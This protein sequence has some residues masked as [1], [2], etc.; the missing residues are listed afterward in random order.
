ML[1]MTMF[2]LTIE[3]VLTDYTRDSTETILN[4]FYFNLTFITMKCSITLLP[5]LVY[6]IKGIDIGFTIIGIILPVDEYM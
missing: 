4:D 1:T 6:Y 5:F 2:T 3:G